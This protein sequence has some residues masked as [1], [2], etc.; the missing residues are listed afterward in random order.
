[1]GLLK[2]KRMHKIM[3]GGKKSVTHKPKAAGL[4]PSADKSKGKFGKK[5]SAFGKKPR[6]GIDRQAIKEKRI[7]MLKE[8]Q[9]KAMIEKKK[10]KKKEEEEEEGLDEYEVNEMESKSAFYFP[11]EQV[12]CFW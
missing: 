3:K 11:S 6:F 1:M 4:R 8:D 2:T 10:N 7:Q 5:P 9:K 12:N